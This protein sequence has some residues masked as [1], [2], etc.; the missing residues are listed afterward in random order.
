M[1]EQAILPLRTSSA[2]AESMLDKARAAHQKYIIKQQNDDLENAI[3]YYIEAIRN[4]SELAEP[5]YR[6]ASLMYE[7]G[8]ISIESAIEQCK[9]AISLEPANANAHIYAG[10]FLSMSED[11]RAAQQEFNLAIKAGCVNSARPRLFL[12][13]L[14]KREM[15][16]EG[17]S[18]L[19]VVKYLYY[20]LSGSVLL[21][22][23]SAAIKMMLDTVVDNISVFSYRTLGET[24][25][26]AKMFTSAYKTYTRGMTKTEHG[27]IFYKKMGDLSMSRQDLLSGLECYRKALKTTPDNREV[28]LKLATLLQTSFPDKIDEAIDYYNRLLEFNIDNDKIYYELG[29]LYLQKEDK[30]NSISAFKLAL[31]YN[32]NN[33]YFNNSLAYAFVRAELYDDAIEYYQRAIKLNPDAQWTSIV[34]HA[35]GAVYGEVKGNLEAAEATYQA[36]LVL[37][38]SNYELLLS[39]GDLLI[40]KGELDR[41][42]R[43]YC[44]AITVNPE[45]FLAYA[46]AGLALWEKD[47]VEEAV[48]SF[49]KSIALN[50]N[51]EIS[52]NNLGVVYLDGLD[53]P[54]EAVGYFQNAIKLN[55]NYTLAYF[56]TARAL[57]ALG[58]NT[59]AAEYYQ[60]SLDLNKLTNELD[61]SDIKSRLHDLFD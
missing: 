6:L 46:K 7:K 49:H 43:T 3:G 41:A 60:M 18:F 45:N 48:V 17:K 53:A 16:L 9:T 4:D 14:I 11:Y 33:P 31:R 27:D 35:L 28:L 56:N 24:F 44:D 29:H 61:D 52:Q 38:P 5:Y 39:L 12:S 30:L 36:G 37:Y 26:K 1:S 23:D 13:R 57:Q 32:E 59:G 10:Y 47:Y 50:P 8:Q 15:M 34:C 58:N 40:A 22:C 19:R 20:L 2:P 51:F 21:M 54:Q 55:P 25:E 42:I